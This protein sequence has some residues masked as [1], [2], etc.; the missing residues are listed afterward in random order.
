MNFANW[1]LFS[2]VAVLAAFSPGPAVL[3]AI[4]N[5]LSVGPR[6]AMISSI[7]NAAGL[8]IVAAV[9]TAGMGLVIAASAFAFGALKL[10]G[11]AYLIFL[12]V[13][14]WRSPSL[15]VAEPAN[16]NKPLRTEASRLFARGLMVA[17][18]NPKAILFFSALFPQFI[19]DRVSTLEQFS[20]LTATYV[21]IC[22]L[23]HGFYVILAQVLKG[24]FSTATRA[25]SFNRASGA[26]F[27]LLGLGL[28]RLRSK[29]T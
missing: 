25:R 24:H 27:V 11:A 26:A 20:V 18:T 5:S 9:V 2:G 21:G 12:G 22:V 4:S 16:T 7:G 14:Q 23:S 8:V 17:L 28:L 1:L 13:K 15:L 29:M 10:I 19:D 3:L 6:R